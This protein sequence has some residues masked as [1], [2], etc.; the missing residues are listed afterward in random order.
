MHMMVLANTNGVLEI[1]SGIRLLMDVLRENENVE[2]GMICMSLFIYN[3]N[4]KRAFYLY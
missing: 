3:C 1:S 4:L 2:F